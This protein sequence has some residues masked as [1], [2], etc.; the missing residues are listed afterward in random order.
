MYQHNTIV[1]GF[2]LVNDA[3]T[4]AALQEARAEIGEAGWKAGYTEER[5]KVARAA[6][7]KHGAPV[8]TKLSGT[9]SGVFTPQTKDAQGNVFQKVRIFL[10]NGQDSTVLSLD[11]GT[12]FCE[13]LLPKLEAAIKDRG[14]S[15]AITIACFPTS[16]DRGGRTFVNHVA[17]VKADGQEV[18]AESHFRRAQDACTAAVAAL[19]KAGVKAKAALDATRKAAKEEYFLGL[20]G[21]VAA[22]FGNTST[23]AEPSEAAAPDPSSG[24]SEEV[25]SAIRRIERTEAARLEYAK[26]W[27]EV[28]FTGDDA[29]QLFDAIEARRK[30]AA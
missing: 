21:E 28:N 29:K 13:R 19:E 7:K 6:L 23:A 10:N 1:S 24:P 2:I 20:A 9:L 18:K 11:L 14:I 25:A 27:V 12:E 17:S 15:V 4:N 3:T 5:S 26:Q 22:L 16:V 8:L 30:T